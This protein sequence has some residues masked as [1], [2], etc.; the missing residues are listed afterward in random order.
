MSPKEWQ[1]DEL[2]QTGVDY[3][4]FEEVQRYDS[5][6]QKLRNIKAEINSLIEFVSPTK[7]SRIL[8][9]GTGTGDFAI[10]LSQLSRH[11]LAVDASRVML[12]YAGRKAIEKEAGN[13]EFCHSGFLTFDESQGPFDIIFSQLALHHLP[14]FWKSI[15]LKKINNAL[16]PGGKFFLKDVIYP[17]GIVDFESFFESIIKG[18]KNTSS[19]ELAKEYIIH[20]REEFSTLDWI[21]EALLKK[22]GFSILEINVENEIIYNYLCSS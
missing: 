17:A 22:A 3:T 4:T 16:K 18:V 21:M 10:A 2:Q 20:I 15:A 14:D 1:Y 6:M 11:V 12:E 7:E 19:A 13:I 8:E 9:I 5:R